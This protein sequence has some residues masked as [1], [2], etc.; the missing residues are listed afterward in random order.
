M[1][2]ARNAC[3]CHAPFVFAGY[4]VLFLRLAFAGHWAESSIPFGQH[5]LP[6]GAW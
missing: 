2:V 6:H 5:A 4:P 3:S 1:V